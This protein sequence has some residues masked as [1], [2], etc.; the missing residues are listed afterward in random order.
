[1]NV[2]RLFVWLGVLAGLHIFLFF[3][4][5]QILPS[6]WDRITVLSV[7]TLPWLPLHSLG[8]PVSR[9]GILPEPNAI[10]W[11]WCLVVWTSFYLA[12][13][14]LLTSLTSNSTDHGEKHRAG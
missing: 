3:G 13:A 8:L 12:V 10:G 6:F 5:P 11:L 14:W 9:H 4:L 7:N 1:M 2:F